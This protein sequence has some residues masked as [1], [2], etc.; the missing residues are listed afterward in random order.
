M[1]DHRHVPAHVP[2]RVQQA[3][4]QAGG[5]RP[6]HHDVGASRLRLRH[7]VRQV[8]LVGI[9]QHAVHRLDAGLLEQLLRGLGAGGAVAGGVADHRYLGALERLQR[10][11]VG[12]ADPLHVG[13]DDPEGERILLR[14]GQL[15][16]GADHQVRYAGPRQDRGG[17]EAFAGVDGSDDEVDLVAE[18]KLL[19]EIDRLGR[20][21]CR[22]TRQQL[23]L[24]AEDSAG[25]VDLLDGQLHAFVLGQRRGGQRPGQRRQPAD[26]DGLGD[27]CAAEQ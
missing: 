19:G 26:L 25:G 23:D 22:V 14:V 3:R 4:L 18:G 15:V 24:A 7:L 13:V 5:G 20:I 21:A 10:I 11:V 12:R 27:G 9:D 6:G 16:D 8:G 2:A 1:T 17:C